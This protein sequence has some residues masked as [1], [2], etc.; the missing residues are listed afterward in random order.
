[1]DIIKEITKKYGQATHNIEEGLNFVSGVFPNPNDPF[2][3]KAIANELENL[4]KALIGMVVP[5]RGGM[6]G[7]FHYWASVPLLQFVT[8]IVGVGAGTAIAVSTTL[9]PERKHAIGKKVVELIESKR[10]ERTN[11]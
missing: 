9:N 10:S 3:A 11:S 2:G 8:A 7:A 5:N 4:S 1:M 6:M